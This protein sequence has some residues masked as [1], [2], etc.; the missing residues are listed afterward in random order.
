MGPGSWFLAPSVVEG[1]CIIHPVEYDR[2][3]LSH[4]NTSIKVKKTNQSLCQSHLSKSPVK[5]ISSKSVIL[6]QKPQIQ[7]TKPQKLHCLQGSNNND[8]NLILLKN[9]SL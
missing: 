7:H 2:G 3:N 8:Q 1:T 5:V 6:Y 9:T 4:I